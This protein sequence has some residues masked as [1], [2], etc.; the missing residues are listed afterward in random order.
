M[1]KLIKIYKNLSCID[2]IE[3]YAKNFYQLYYYKH[4]LKLPRI[5]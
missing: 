2:K 5:W 3:I 1:Y 4:T